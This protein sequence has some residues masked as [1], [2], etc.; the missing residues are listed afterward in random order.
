MNKRALQEVAKF[1][2]GLVAADLITE[3]WLATTNML[4]VHF[5]GFDF[6]PEMLVPAVV[7]DLALLF[8]LIH[9]GWHIGK[10]P[11]PREH[12]YL[13]VVGIIFAVV[14]LAHLWRLFAAG[15]LAIMGWEVPLWLSWF[16]VLLTTYM[17]YASFRLALRTR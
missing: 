14:A 4:P 8:I 7:F 13:L 5:L 10:I 2:A 15:D 6:S 11:A 12:T 17:S 3:A 1:A 9:W 16:G